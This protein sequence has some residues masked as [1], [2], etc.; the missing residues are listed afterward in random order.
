MNATGEPLLADGWRSLPAR[1]R[2]IALAAI[3]LGFAGGSGCGVVGPSCLEHQG[4]VTTIS[5]LLEA[6]QIVTHTVTYDARGSENEIRITWGGQRT[7][8]GPRLWLYATGLDCEDFSPPPGNGP[9]A[10]SGPCRN[11]SGGAGGYPAPDARPCV[12][13]NTCQP[14]PDEMVTTSLTVFGQGNGG[15][16]VSGYKLH[17]VGDRNQSASYSIS[18]T[19]WRDC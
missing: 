9:S 1:P 19:W 4:A 7:P 11:I 10:D 16:P 15:R 2:S 18:I 14:T 17:V 6:G 12:H 8:G 13:A 3:A 5:G